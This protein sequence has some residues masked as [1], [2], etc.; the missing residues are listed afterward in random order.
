MTEGHS[1]CSRLPSDPGMLAPLFDSY[2]VGSERSCAHLQIEQT[3]MKV[4]GFG[5]GKNERKLAGEGRSASNKQAQRD[6]QS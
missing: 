5:D 3:S 6:R 1:L 2:S 4:H